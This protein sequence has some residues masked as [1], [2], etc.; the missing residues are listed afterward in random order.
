M[1]VILRIRRAFLMRGPVMLTTEGFSASAEVTLITSPRPCRIDKAHV[2]YHLTTSSRHWNKKI[3]AEYTV[4]Q[5][6]V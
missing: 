3:L 1:D 4:S 5:T 2:L 6:D